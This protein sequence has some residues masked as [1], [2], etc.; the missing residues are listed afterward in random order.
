MSEYH[1]NYELQKRLRE[2]NSSICCLTVAVE[3]GTSNGGYN[4]EGQA[5]I[6]SAGVDTHT[7]AAG[8]IHSY[9]VQ[10]VG[11]GDTIEISIDGGSTVEYTTGKSVE[12]TTVNTNEIEIVSTSG[13]AIISWT[14][15]V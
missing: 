11:S 4:S 9:S 8:T 5:L 13:S 14:Y 1:S 2:L 12:Y 7:F 15:N 10:V 6:E 3:T